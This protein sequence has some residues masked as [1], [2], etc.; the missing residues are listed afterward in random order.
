[1]KLSEIKL[2]ETVDHHSD[3][4]LGIA[5]K[6][7]KEGK[8]IIYDGLVRLNPNKPAFIPLL[9][10]VAQISDAGAI[11]VY[12]DRRYFMVA[13]VDLHNFNWDLG[14]HKTDSGSYYTLKSTWKS[15]ELGESASLDNMHLKIIQSYLDK[16]KPVY[17]DATSASAINASRQG[18]PSYMTIGKVLSIKQNALVYDFMPHRLPD[19]NTIS[20]SFFIA[21]E[22]FDE[23]YEMEETTR[24][25]L[26]GLWILDK[27]KSK[28]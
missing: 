17:I 5:A 8:R 16:G 28:K 10:E 20:R 27:P 11:E 21:A 14:E 6:L 4:V 25:E 2:L 26:T 13:S 12:A 7:R 22:P 3:L 9:G 19:D 24:L 18:K 15:E 1:M 23:H